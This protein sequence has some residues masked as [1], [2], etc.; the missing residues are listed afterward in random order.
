MMVAT[1]APIG[2]MSRVYF[3]PKA[4]LHAPRKQSAKM[5]GNIM[6]SVE[7]QIQ[8]D[9]SLCTAVIASSLT[10][11]LA[12]VTLSYL[13]RQTWAGLPDGK[14]IFALWTFLLKLSRVILTSGNHNE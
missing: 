4:S 11:R 1:S 9:V 13:L 7:D 10:V 5:E 3:L 6:Q 12:Q 2:G 14:L 8:K